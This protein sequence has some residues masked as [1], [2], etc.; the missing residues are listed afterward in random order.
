MLMA[1][2]VVALVTLGSAGN[3]LGALMPGVGPVAPDQVLLADTIHADNLGGS[4]YDCVG[5]EWHF[6]INGL[7]G[8]APTSIT[9]TWSDGGSEVLPLDTSK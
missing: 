7:D 4:N 8:N 6:I 9:V 3:A 2:C 1:L 5:N